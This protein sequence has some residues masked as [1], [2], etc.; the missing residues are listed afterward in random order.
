MFSFISTFIKGRLK[1]GLDIALF[2][3]GLCLISSETVIYPGS[4]AARITWHGIRTPI[5][6]I[7]QIGRGKG[8]VD[9]FMVPAEHGINSGKAGKRGHFFIS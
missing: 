9:V 7:E 4:I 2:S 1:Y 5:F 3:D 8:N 6:L